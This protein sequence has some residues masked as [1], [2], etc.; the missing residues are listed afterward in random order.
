MYTK[1]NYTMYNYESRASGVAGHGAVGEFPAM[2]KRRRKRRT[3]KG[4]DLPISGWREWV[5]LPQLGMGPVKAKI[6]TGARSS[7][8][9]AFGVEQ[10]QR[11]GKEMLRFSVHPLQRDSKTSVQAEAELIDHR[12]VRNSGGHSELRPVIRTELELGEHRWPIEL[13]LTRRDEMGFRMLLGRQAIRGRFAVDAGGSFR[14][15]DAG[16]SGSKKSGSKKGSPSKS[17]LEKTGPIKTRPKKKRTR[18][19]K[20]VGSS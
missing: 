18:R 12:T 9:H 15:C 6:D 16:K 7:C 17:R 11:D 8:L 20:V 5:S 1:Y 19:V 10:F 2:E 3:S 4:K 13:T 14:L